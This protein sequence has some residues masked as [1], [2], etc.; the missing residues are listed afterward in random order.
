MHQAALLGEAI[1]DSKKFGWELG[2]TKVTHNWENMVMAVQGQDWKFEFLIK[3]AILVGY[4]EI[5]QALSS[6]ECRN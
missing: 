2:E 5:N 6:V 1:H 4:S 3:E